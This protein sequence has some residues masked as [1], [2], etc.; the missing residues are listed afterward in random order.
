M[1]ATNKAKYLL[2]CKHRHTF[3]ILSINTIFFEHLLIP[4]KIYLYQP[5]PNILP[6]PTKK[7]PHNIIKSVNRCNISWSHHNH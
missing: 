1:A 5:K 4:T 7:N 6:H 2:S 3:K